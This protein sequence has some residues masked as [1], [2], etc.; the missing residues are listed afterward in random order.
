MG[1]WCRGP[2]S[3]DAG[4]GDGEADG[5]ESCFVRKIV[6]DWL[7]EGRVHQLAFSAGNRSYSQYFQQKGI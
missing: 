4:G 6:E 7:K 1:S 2:A 5:L 3:K